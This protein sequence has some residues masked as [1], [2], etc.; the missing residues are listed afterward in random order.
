MA[1]DSWIAAQVIR[2][3]VKFNERGRRI[4]LRDTLIGAL[5][6]DEVDI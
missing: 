1:Y 3:E 2:Y 6:N 4:S 5:E